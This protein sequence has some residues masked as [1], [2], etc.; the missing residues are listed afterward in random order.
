MLITRWPSIPSCLLRLP[1]SFAKHTFA[2]WN[3]LQA[4]LIISAS[5]MLVRSTGA[6]RPAYN[7][8][9]RSAERWSLAPITVKGGSAKSRTAVVS[10]M[11]SGFMQTPKSGPQDFPDFSSRAGMMM[12]STVPGSTVLRMLTTT[13]RRKLLSSPPISAITLSICARPR[14]PLS[15]LGVPTQTKANSP[16]APAVQSAC[17]L[18]ACTP[19]WTSFSRSGSMIGLRPAL[20]IETFVSSTSTPVTSWPSSA[21]QEA[22]TQP[23]YPSPNTVTFMR[24]SQLRGAELL[25]Q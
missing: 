22:V 6:V 7:S 23:T 8:A 2:A 9:T 15:L 12:P 17:S 13:Y 11:N 21:R 3:A 19:R 16:N 18:R 4:Y 14:L 24:L 20:T 1:I 10:R 5:R 25:G